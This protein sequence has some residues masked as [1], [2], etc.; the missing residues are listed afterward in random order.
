VFLG[1]QGADLVNGGDGD[2]VALLGAGDDTFA[3]NPGDDNDTIEGQDGSDTL[4]FNGSAVAENIDIA[5]NG[6][7]VLFFRNVAAVTMDMNDTE[8]VTFN[9]LGG[10]DNVVV[11][12]LSGTDAQQ[13]TLNLAGTLNGATGDAQPDNV[14]VNGTTGADT[15]TVGGSAAAGVT[16]AGLAS[17]V[18]IT[19]SEPAN[20]RLT[21]NAL[22][23]ADVVD[24]SGLPAGVIGLTLNGGSEN[25]VL[26][27]SQG[28]DL[29]DGGAGGD[30]MIGGAGNDQLTGG[31]GADHFSGG[32]GTDTATDFN[33][34]EGDT[35]DTIP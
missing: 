5:A 33:A 12:D 18:T 19:T 22:A 31:L 1:S 2:D 25:D 26:L 16:V 20:D 23:G 8:L 29:I 11:G 28:A 27:G 32:A 10:A 35:Q 30:V 9:A 14:I 13:I 24:A 17:T 34:G 6:G 7:R 21:V 15:I 3:W 4:L